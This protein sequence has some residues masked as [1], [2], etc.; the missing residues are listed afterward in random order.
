MRISQI[1]LLIHFLPF[2]VVSGCALHVN[3]AVVGT[4][5]IGD[6]QLNY[7]DFGQG[8]PLVLVSGGSSM[9]LRQWADVIPT[10]A[11]EYRVITYDPRGIGKSDNPTARYSDSADLEKLLDHLQLDR[12]GLIGL[13][14]AGG[15]V[16]EFAATRPDR[17]AGVVAIAPFIPGFEFSSSMKARIEKFNLAAEK[18]RQPFLDSIF[19][20]PH[21]IPAPINFSIR[22]KARKI[23]GE[24]YDKGAGFD[25]TFQITVDPPLIEQLNMI[26]A[27]VLLLAGELDHPEFMRRNEF[28]TENIHIVS[29]TVIIHSG[30]T[31][32]MENPAALLVAIAP[33]LNEISQQER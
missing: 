24:N 28:L 13:S 22:Q 11:D 1:R 17:V 2:F 29:A 20:D 31:V 21:F 23:M 27:P 7:E 14:S 30:H 3:T 8:F 19:A 15:F 16:L 25:P 9:D 32:P 33:F 10:L 4:F 6:D 18:G 12:V 5:E 26:D